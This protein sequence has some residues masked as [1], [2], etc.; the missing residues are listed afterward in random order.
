MKIRI[1]KLVLLSFSLVILMTSCNKTQDITP[2]F[3]RCGNG[4][5]LVGGNLVIAGY[6]ST[7]GNGYDATLVMANPETGD[8][9]W[10]KTYGNSY[11]DAFYSVKKSTKGG[12]VAAGFTNR[13][14]ASSPAMLLVITDIKGKL[15]N[16]KTYGGSAYSQGFNVLPTA[17]SGYLVSGYIQKNSNSDRDI[18]LVKT[19]ISGD[20]LWTKSFGAKSTN[21]YDTVNDAAYGVI[22]A[23]DG[24]YFVT[25]SLNGYT[26][27][28]GKIFLKKL[29]SVGEELWSKTYGIGIGY[30]ISLTHDNGKG[31]VNGI[32][33]SGSL[34]EGSS[35]DIFLLKTD[36]DGKKLWAKSYGGS[37]FEYGASMIETTGGGFA[38]TGITDSKGAGMQ[39]AYLILTDAAGTST[40]DP[41]YGGS[42]NDQGF[43]IVEMP[44]KGFAITGLSNTGGSFIF[45]NRVKANGSQYWAS[46]K[47]L[48]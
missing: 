10:T 17:D 11:S 22:A 6:N 37:G 20:T 31:E 4:L 3:Q 39:D 1:L 32:A 29:S 21:P 13:A 16:S 25:G 45:L 41:T 34:Q 48:P 42:D 9:L 33:I 5:A 19:N 18:Y 38:I 27:D 7:S 23:P 46:P 2:Q 24:G 15:V 40:A 36:L 28:G 35:Q 47:Y 26:Q 30:S 43:G 44:D 8:T 12:I 14:N